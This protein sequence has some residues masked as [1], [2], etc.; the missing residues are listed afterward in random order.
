[1]W[2]GKGMGGGRDVLPGDSGGWRREALD[3]ACKTPCPDLNLSHIYV[4]YGSKRAEKKNDKHGRVGRYT[5]H[6]E[7]KRRLH[8]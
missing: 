6:A 1:M 2:C 3:K 5:K 8:T 7:M 4:V